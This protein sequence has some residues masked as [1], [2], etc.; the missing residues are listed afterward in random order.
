MKGNNN[1]VPRHPK[2]PKKRMAPGGT[3]THTIHNLG[4]HPTI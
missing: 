1:I 4:K 3:Q 2:Y